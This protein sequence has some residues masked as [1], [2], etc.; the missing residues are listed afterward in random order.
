M[1]FKN[2]SI[3]IAIWMTA[4]K[5]S[6]TRFL[7]TLVSKTLQDKVVFKWTTSDYKPPKGHKVIDNPT[8]VIHTKSLKKVW[9][10][11]TQ[12]RAINTIIVDCLIKR[13]KENPKENVILAP[14]FIRANQGDSWLIN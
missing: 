4:L 9:E 6:T 7:K 13:V 10:M 11:H 2:E 14:P 1:C 3:D 5:Q 8:K 12:Y